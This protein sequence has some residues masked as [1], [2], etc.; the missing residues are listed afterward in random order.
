M[1]REGSVSFVVG[2]SLYVMGGSIHATSVER[3]DVA[4]NTWTIMANTLSGRRYF[5]AVTMSA[6]PVEEQ[7]LFDSLIA[8]SSRRRP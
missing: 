2:G 8:K 1:E 4:S 5:C 6:G 3:Y 7:D